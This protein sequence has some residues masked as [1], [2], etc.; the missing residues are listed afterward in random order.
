[1]YPSEYPVITPTVKRLSPIIGAVIIA[2]G[3]IGYAIHEHHAARSLATQNQQATAQL[4]ATHIEID[5]LSSKVNALLANA[6]AAPP[7]V[8]APQPA[9]APSRDVTASSHP[10]PSHHTGTRANVRPNAYDPRYNKLQSQVDAQGKLIDAQRGDIDSARN[11][12]NSTRGDIASTRSDL[13]S[14]RTELSGSIART[15]NDLV[16]LEKKG[17]RSY[18][19]FDL[20]K[21]K[22]FKREGPVSISLRKADTKHG[23]ADLALI[24]DD[25]N[26]TQ[27]HVNLYQP[28]MFYQPDT[29]LPVE[30]V[31]NNMSKNH[32]HG[33]VSA[34]KYHRSEL[35]AAAPDTVASPVTPSVSDQAASAQPASRQRLPLLNDIDQE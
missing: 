26:L 8:A 14:A 3:G 15:H 5:T 32:I 19:E 22:D 34:P 27:K 12:L 31:I 11:D 10:V 33:Y 20:T 9:P 35:A 21:S 7:T 13:A 18:F 23:F 1:M 30:V 25:R 6:A 28:A 24:V 16:L 29:H 4:A 2:G 17:E